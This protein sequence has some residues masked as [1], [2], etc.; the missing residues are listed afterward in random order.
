MT[1]KHKHDYEVREMSQSCCGVRCNHADEG[2][3]KSKNG[4]EMKKKRGDGLSLLEGDA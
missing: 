4:K 3:N 2:I 1:H